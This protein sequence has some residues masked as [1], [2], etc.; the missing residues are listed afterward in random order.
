MHKHF[1]TI[2]IIAMFSILEIGVGCQNSGGGPNSN[3]QPAATAVETKSFSGNFLP[4]PGPKSWGR[5]EFKASGLAALYMSDLNNPYM[6][7]AFERTGGLITIKKVGIRDNVYE[8]VDENTIKDG[9]TVYVK[10]P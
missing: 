7:C 6:T 2:T 1:H 3:S 4:Q 9:N 5:I 10:T 8:V